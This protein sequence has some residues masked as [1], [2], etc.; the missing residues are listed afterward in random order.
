MSENSFIL[1]LKDFLKLI[2]VDYTV[3]DTMFHLRD[4]DVTIVA[5]S[6]EGSSIPY[7]VS[8]EYE[9][10]SGKRFI[11]YEDLWYT[12]GEII[13]NRLKA[14]LGKG[15]VLF[16]RKCTVSEITSAEA[17]VFLESHHLLGSAKS[18]Y[19]YGLF[20]NNRLV[21]VATFS[22]PR[23]IKRGDQSVNSYE[24]VRYASEGSLRIAGGMG[25]LLNFF[26]DKESPQD[27]MSYADCDWSAGKVYQELG[28]IFAGKTKPVEFYVN[29]NTYQ[30]VSAKKLMCDRN[31]RHKELDIKD[32]VLLFNT[33]NLKFIRRFPIF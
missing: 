33:G 27:I 16:A 25:K 15:E 7:I 23:Q 26:I 12:K 13:R 28:F 8:D 4:F 20:Y 3:K 2:G 9:I 17:G 11:V 32:Y 5:M 10:T 22:L 18:R 30:R 29:R 21:A 19:R 14:N 31:Y 6:L 24:W 1:E